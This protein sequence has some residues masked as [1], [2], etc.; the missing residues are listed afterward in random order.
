MR[1]KVAENAAIVKQLF[2]RSLLLKVAVYTLPTTSQST[3]HSFISSHMS[4]FKALGTASNFLAIEKEIS[5]FNS[6]AIV[7]VQAP[8]EHTV[9]YGGGTRSGPA[10]I[11]KASHFVEFYDEELDRELCYDVGIG[12]L[13]PLKFGKRADRKALDIIYDGTRQLLEQNKFVVMLGGEHTIS[14]A[15][16]RAH[17]ERYSDLSVLQF[18]AHSDLRE[19]YQGSMYSHASVMAR[20]CEFLSP[21]RLVQVGIRAQCI[22][23]SQFIKQKGITT[24]Y[25]H[26]IRNPKRQYDWMDRV[27]ERLTDH[28]YVSFDV[29]GFD[30]SIMPSTGTPEPNGLWWAETMTLLRR[31]GEQKKIV[32]CDIVELAPEKGVSHPDLTAAKLVYKLMNYAFIK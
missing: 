7:V 31:V 10:A 30:P 5:T 28:V 24:L 32:G 8:Y 19:S 17:L 15:P 14:Q 2:V 29:D 6:S 12:T 26:E 23:E 22:E 21:Q 18:D 27:L 11:I 9:S 13:E 16:I 1:R 20:V 3:F 4:S 25:A